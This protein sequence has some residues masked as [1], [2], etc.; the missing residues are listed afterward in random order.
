MG[1]D[2]EMTATSLTARVRV[3]DLLALER[4]LREVPGHLLVSGGDSLNRLMEAIPKGAF[5][6][7]R[8][9]SGGADA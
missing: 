3:A 9:G 5:E 8:S 1:A 7:A 4:V 6:A 2:Q